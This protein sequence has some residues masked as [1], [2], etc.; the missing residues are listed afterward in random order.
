MTAEAKKTKE[1]MG[2]I[3]P[4]LTAALSALGDNDR[5]A[6]LADAVSPQAVF[7]DEGVLELM[8]AQFGALGFDSILDRIGLKALP[9]AAKIDAE[10]AKIDRKKK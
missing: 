3:S 4:D 7:G 1:V 2:A 10:R 6:K 8:K 5:I 9:D